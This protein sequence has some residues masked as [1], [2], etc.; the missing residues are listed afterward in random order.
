MTCS[1]HIASQMGTNVSANQKKSMLP[2]FPT[3]DVTILW[4]KITALAHGEL[5]VKVGKSKRCS[6]NEL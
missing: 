1:D 4:K 2:E 6:K 5:V 3:V